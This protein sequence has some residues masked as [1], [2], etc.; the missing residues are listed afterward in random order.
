MKEQLKQLKEGFNVL[1]PSHLLVSFTAKELE[2]I[3]SGEHG[4]DVH[5]LQ[6]R[7]KYT[8]GY[9]KGS[10]VIRWLWEVLAAYSEVRQYALLCSAHAH[11]LGQCFTAQNTRTC[12]R[13]SLWSVWGAT[14]TDYDAIDESTL[15]LWF[16]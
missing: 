1:I 15:T 10:E 11:T 8:A 9:T 4:V 16:L 6:K 2:Q 14:A 3:I 7:A 13:C 12:T 5:V